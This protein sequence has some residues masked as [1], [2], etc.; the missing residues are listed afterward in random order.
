MLLPVSGVVPSRVRIIS[1]LAVCKS[2]GEIYLKY[3]RMRSSNS[4]LETMTIVATSHQSD[5]T[6]PEARTAG[7]S[8][9]CRPDQCRTLWSKDGGGCAHPP[10]SPP[11]WLFKCLLGL[12]SPIFS[13]WSLSWP[14]RRRCGTRWG[15]WVWGPPP[16]TAGRRPHSSWSPARFCQ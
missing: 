11:S 9:V 12:N 3:L 15:G 13:I 2:W 7:R 1:K 4:P 10:P 8:P 16:C 14:H 6:G 5:V